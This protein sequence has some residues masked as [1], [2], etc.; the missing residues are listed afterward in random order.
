MVHCKKKY[1]YMFCLVSSPN[2]WKILNQEAF[3]GQVQIIVLFSEKNKSKFS[4]F[5]LTKLNN[6]PTG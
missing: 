1:S 5:F 3:S 4:E 2:I 6:L